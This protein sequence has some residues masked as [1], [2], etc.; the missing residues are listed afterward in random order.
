MEKQTID[1]LK[2]TLALLLVFLFVATVTAAAVSAKQTVQAAI[3]TPS[4]GIIQDGKTVRG[5]Y[6]QKATSLTNAEHYQMTL[7]FNNV[8]TD[9]E[10]F[11]GVETLSSP[12]SG[13]TLKASVSGSY[14]SIAKTITWEV[15][16]TIHATSTETPSLGEIDTGT[17][18]KSPKIKGTGEY[19]GLLIG[20]F[21]LY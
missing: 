5:I 19:Q 13:G 9:A 10:T 12:Q 8:D 18:G 20:S 6:D 7:T 1:R 4:N 15:V 17:L 2:K 21:K 3:A 11:E 14:D 16:D